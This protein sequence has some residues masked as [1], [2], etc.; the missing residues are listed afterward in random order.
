LSK[1]RLNFGQRFEHNSQ[2]LHRRG[3]DMQENLP[4]K[5]PDASSPTAGASKRRTFRYR[6]VAVFKHVP[7]VRRSWDP[8]DFREAFPDPNRLTRAHEN[9][10]AFLPAAVRRDADGMGG[11]D[12]VSQFAAHFHA[13]RHIPDRQGAAA[14]SLRESGRN[15]PCGGRRPRPVLRHPCKYPRC[16]AGLSRAAARLEI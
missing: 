14:P 8:V 3:A 2:G 6:N 12:C 1:V 4:I 16:I 7:K 10:F 9:L 5:H 13:R 15:P 11:K